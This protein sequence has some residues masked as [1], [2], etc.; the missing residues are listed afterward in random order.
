VSRLTLN[1]NRALPQE[2]RLPSGVSA[3]EAGSDDGE[4]RVTVVAG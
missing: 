3:H 2:N 4:P 1:S